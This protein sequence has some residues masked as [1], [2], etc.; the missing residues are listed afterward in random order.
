MLDNLY[1]NIG[2]KIKG[3]AKWSFVI[4]ALGAII[5]GIALMATDED[6]IGWGF[7]T[8][9]LGSL[10]AFVSSWIL[11]GFGLLVDDIHAIRDKEGTTKESN[12]RR[13]EEEIARLEAEEKARIE[14]ELNP[15]TEDLLKK[16]LEVISKD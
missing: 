11:Y 16:I 13:R 1:K 4:E 8:M 10:I 3:L 2:C 5:G 15:T 9:S 7:L 14:R 6:Y 12:K